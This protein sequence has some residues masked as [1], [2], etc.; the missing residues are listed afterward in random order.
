[1]F[2]STL[3]FFQVYP[4]QVEAAGE[5]TYIKS[6]SYDLNGNVKDR[7]TPDGDF[8]QYTY[9]KLNRLTVKS[10]P[11]ASSVSY[12]YDANG[13][14]KEMTDA[15]GTT[16]YEYDEFNRLAGLQFPGI[17][18]IYYEYDKSGNRTKTIYP[19]NEEVSYFMIMTTV[20]SA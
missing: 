15:S 11:D 8:I 9:D 3:L 16:L 18:P 13:N 19:N 14:R 5:I 17:N 10:Y 1:M 4:T 12:V 2:F 7:T 20:F 6:Y